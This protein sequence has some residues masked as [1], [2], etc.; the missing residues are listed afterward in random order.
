MSCL[1]CTTCQCHAF[2][3][4]KHG[5]EPRKIISGKGNRSLANWSQSARLGIGGEFGGKCCPLLAR[6]VTAAPP[7]KPQHP[8]PPD[9][10]SRPPTLDLRPL[11]LTVSTV[12]PPRFSSSPAQ[13]LSTASSY[14]S[15]L[16]GDH[17]YTFGLQPALNWTNAKR[18]GPTTDGE[19]TL[20]PV[21]I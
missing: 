9:F 16:C 17:L 8:Q 20:A 12:P 2:M 13:T 15:S 21:S 19:S 7:S 14:C 5:A 10:F 6:L 1:G 4:G 11:A 3:G 18:A